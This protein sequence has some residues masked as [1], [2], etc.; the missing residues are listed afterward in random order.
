MHEMH[1]FNAIASRHPHT[2]CHVRGARKEC[3]FRNCGDTIR[4]TVLQMR[5]SP[6]SSINNHPTV[7]PLW[8]DFGRAVQGND[9]KHAT[10]SYL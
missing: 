2:Q 1:P 10:H 6:A 7:H 3:N 8:P 5:N 9:P 4:L